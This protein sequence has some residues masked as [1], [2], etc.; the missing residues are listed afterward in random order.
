MKNNLKNLSLKATAIGSIPHNDVSLVLDFIFKNF[1]IPFCPQL[2]LLSKE[3]DMIIEYT[4][5]LCGLEYNKKLEKY[6]INQETEAFCED[7]EKFYNDYFEIIENKNLENIEKYAI[8]EPYSHSI[9]GF[10]EKIKEI[11]PTFTKCQIT[12]PFTWETSLVDTQNRCAYYDETLREINK[13]TLILKAIWQIEKI[14]S[15]SNETVPIVFIDEPALASFG[16]SIFITLKKDEVVASINSISQKIKE[17]G[18][19]SAIHCCGKVDWGLVLQTGVD[20][21]NLDS[22]SYAKSLVAYSKELN[23]FFNN[24]GIVAW[25]VTPTLDMNVLSKV[26]FEILKDKFN[27]AVL[28]LT[29]KGLDKKFIYEHSMFTP[30]C[31]TGS[32]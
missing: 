32:L 3:E 15:V 8:T 16:T 11:K 6:V 9:N 18:A 26:D 20:I 23:D 10:F 7:F 31:G 25:G 24:G 21:I 5:G 14:K 29:K 19:I 2:P 22:Y 17:F 13:K 30:A 28:N 12:G 4:Q 27:E 1:E